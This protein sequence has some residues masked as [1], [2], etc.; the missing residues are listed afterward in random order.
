MSLWSTSTIKWHGMWLRVMLD[1]HS[2]LILSFGKS[3]ED[4]HLAVEDQD[5]YFR[6]PHR[7]TPRGRK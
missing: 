1:L 2:R 5:E 7:V 3:V 4:H 6:V